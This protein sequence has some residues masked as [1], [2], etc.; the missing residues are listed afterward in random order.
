M[1]T[2]SQLD[3]LRFRSESPT[4][5]GGSLWSLKTQLDS[6]DLSLSV[7]GGVLKGAALGLVWAALFR[8]WMRLISDK[9]EFTISG[10]AILLGAATFVGACAGLAFAMRRRGRSKR[11]WI[12]RAISVLAFAALGIGPGIFVVPTILFATLAL[13]RTKWHVLLRVLCALL[14]LT[15][16]GVICRIMLNFWPPAPAALYLLLYAAF[17]YPA[18]IAM[19]MGI[20][21][22]SGK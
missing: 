4:S 16:F 22:R 10:T 11:L 17:L 8:G 5:G 13:A 3:S 12:H 15:G 7:A 14:A 19:R 9:P 1:Q 21:P 2:V 18:V 20:A 6:H